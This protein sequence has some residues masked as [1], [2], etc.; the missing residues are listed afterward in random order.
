MI[1]TTKTRAAINAGVTICFLSII[2]FCALLMFDAAL[3]A[4]I[5]G[6]VLAMIDYMI[7]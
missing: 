6:G 1:T 3:A 7:D 4:S 5:I 2:G